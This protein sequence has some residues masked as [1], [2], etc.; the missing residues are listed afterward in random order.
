[1]LHVVN[2]YGNVGVRVCKR[3]KTVEVLA[4]HVHVPKIISHKHENTNYRKLECNFR[5]DVNE[6][7]V[8]KERCT[9]YMPL[10]NF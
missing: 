10:C 8:A 6:L 2:M 1:M 7:S 4:H 3:A 9:L 5:N